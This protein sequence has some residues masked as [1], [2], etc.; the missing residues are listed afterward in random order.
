MD[1]QLLQNFLGETAYRIPEIRESLRVAASD[2]FADM[3]LIRSQLTALARSASSLGLVEVAGYAGSMDVEIARFQPGTSLEPAISILTKL[4]AALLRAS[5]DDAAFSLDIVGLENVLS[6]PIPDPEPFN[7]SIDDFSGRPSDAPDEL[8]PIPEPQFLAPELFTQPMPVVQ[9]EA[10]DEF[11]VDPELLEV[12]AEEAEDLLKN[13]D[14]SLE[15]LSRDPA[16]SDSLWEIRRNAHTFKGSAGIVGLKQL[17]ELAHRVEDLLDRM[18]ET[19][20]GSND[21]IIKLLHASTECLKSLV[22][23][24]TSPT[25]FKSISQ[26]YYDFDG[27]LAA[28]GQ[29]DESIPTIAAIEPE[30]E[31][32]VLE[33][34]L[35]E[36]NN[37]PNPLTDFPD[38]SA[39]ARLLAPPTLEFAVPRSPQS[40]SV[41]RVSLERLDDLVRIVRDMLISRSVYEQ[42]LKSLERQIDDLHNATRRL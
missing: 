28:M 6:E 24:E 21:R 41:V 12:F 22:A 34:V 10:S 9:E 37:I 18:A 35:T 8:L 3:G 15:N 7:F 39:I 23:G 4:E 38:R 30:P 19:K 16:D 26:L 33:D 20:C 2:P 29:N 14:A 40:R 5:L 42:N 27:V 31:V 17:S 36:A 32:N 25:L 11:D 1:A 13:I